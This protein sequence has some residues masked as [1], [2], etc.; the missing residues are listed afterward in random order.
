MIFRTAREAL[1]TAATDAITARSYWSDIVPSDVTPYYE[2]S[3]RPG[4]GYVH[5]DRVEYPDRL[6]GVAFWN[7]VI[8]LP[9]DLAAA[10]RFIEECLPPLREAL[11]AEM[12]V[13]SARPEQLNL[14]GAGL[15]PCLFINGHRE[16]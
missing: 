14:T 4:G 8:L 3:T 16:E 10:E 15:L 11:S 13:T 5:L 1:A 9:Q 2:Q 6:G 12:V 7:V